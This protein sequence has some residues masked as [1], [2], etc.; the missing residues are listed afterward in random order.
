MYVVDSSAKYFV[1]WRQ[2]K[3]GN[4]TMQFII[5]SMTAL[6]NFILLA[7]TC[8]N[9]KG[10][11]CCVF[12]EHFEYFNDIYS[13][14]GGLVVSMLAS[15]T[16]ARGFKPEKILSMPSLRKGSKAVCPMSQICGM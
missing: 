9:T 4:T 11:N 3:R 2:C 1:P 8:V 6:R 15:G 5:V 7:A 14:F 10:A 12:E 16:R 13:G